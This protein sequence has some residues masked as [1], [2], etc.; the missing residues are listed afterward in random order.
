[1]FWKNFY[2]PITY[3][4][5]YVNPLVTGF[6]MQGLVPNYPYYNFGSG[7]NNNSIFLGWNNWSFGGNNN[8]S[9]WYSGDYI[10]PVYNFT[11]GETASV[12]TSKKTTSIETSNKTT[13]TKNKK[14]TLPIKNNKTESSKELRKSF[15]SNAMKYMGYNEKDGTSR[16]FSSSKEWCADFVTYVVKESYKEKGLKAPEWFGHHRTEILRKQAKDHNQY[17]C[18]T[19]KSNRAKTIAQKV[20][21]G[22]IP[23]WRENG[24]SHTGFVTKVYQDGS[25]DT[26]E[27]NRDD[28]V[29][30]WHYNPNEPT[31]SG[32]IRLTG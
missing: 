32:F 31:L 15:T 10:G 2:K 28:K 8:Q 7:Q 14:V 24:A 17:L 4:N 12:D 3:D 27:G 9:G 1:M 30:K 22:D 21:V 11:G 18:I 25:F 16:K 23:I 19:D 5:P 26:I 29:C 20:N 13:T 6:N